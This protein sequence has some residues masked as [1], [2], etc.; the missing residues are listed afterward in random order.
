VPSWFWCYVNIDIIVFSLNSQGRPWFF[1]RSFFVQSIITTQ[2][3]TMTEGNLMLHC[4]LGIRNT[5]TFYTFRCPQSLEMIRLYLCKKCK[6]EWEMLN[7]A[8]KQ[9]LLWKNQDRPCWIQREN[10]DVNVY[11]TSSLSVK[12]KCWIQRENNDVNI[13]IKFKCKKRIFPFNRYVLNFPGV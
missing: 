2:S 9:K 11:A 4:G 12:R 6:L 1:Q 10:N 8:R 13:K 5:N 7:S 3:H